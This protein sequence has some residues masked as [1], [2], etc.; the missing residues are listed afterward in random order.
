MDFFLSVHQLLD[1]MSSTTNQNTAPH[2][3]RVS[4]RVRAS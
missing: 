1:A 2:K 4:S 3:V